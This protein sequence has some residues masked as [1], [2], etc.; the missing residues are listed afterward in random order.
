M[1]W[2][3]AASAG[4]VLVLLG[5]VPASA[6]SCVQLTTS[7]RM[8]RAGLVAEVVVEARTAAASG[9]SAAEVVYTMRALRVFKGP[10]AASYRVS[11]AASGASCGLE[12]IGVGDTVV[13]FAQ[14][15]IDPGF[16]PGSTEWTANLC[17]GTAPATPTLVDEVADVLGAGVAVPTQGTTGS[18]GDP[19]VA[20]PGP[21]GWGAGATGLAILAAV[22]AGGAALWY[23]GRRPRG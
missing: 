2:A 18:T 20:G 17:G 4:L 6:C 7:E 10:A 12:G 3:A 13:L 23:L 16:S 22:L 14:A 8:T 5:A 9:S 1:R 19:T 15:P 11:S 21:G